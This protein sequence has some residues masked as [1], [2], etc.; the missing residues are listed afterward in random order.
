MQTHFGPFAGTQTLCRG[1][2]CFYSSRR[3][4]SWS[5]CERDPVIETRYDWHTCS[6]SV[7]FKKQSIWLIHPLLSEHDMKD[8]R[9]RENTWERITGEKVNTSP[10]FTE[11]HYYYSNKGFKIGWNVT[12]T[13]CISGSVTQNELNLRY[14]SRIIK[15][16]KLS[17]IQNCLSNALGLNHQVEGEKK[18]FYACLGKNTQKSPSCKNGSKYVKAH[19]PSEQYSEVFF[20]IN[21][22]LL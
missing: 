15:H 12:G 2:S 6:F 20:T 5:V 19:S 18:Y 13:Y 8:S 1:S 3:L 14:E 16:S 17:H 4:Y 11:E 7:L 10:N 22:W 21:P 9:L